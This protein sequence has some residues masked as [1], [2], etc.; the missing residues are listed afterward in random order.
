MRVLKAAY[1]NGIFTKLILTVL[2][3][4]AGH[5]TTTSAFAAPLPVGTA[6]VA[7]A[8]AKP[9]GASNLLLSTGPVPF[10]APGYTGFLTSS[11]YDGDSTNPFGP[12]ALTFTYLLTNN[13][14]STH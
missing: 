12:T 11:V 6:V 10:A 8:E 7:T 13:G 2:L 4:A 9:D 1:R 14:T 5:L 3:V